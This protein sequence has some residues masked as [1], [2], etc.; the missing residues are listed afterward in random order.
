MQVARILPLLPPRLCPVNIRFQETSLLSCWPDSGMSLQFE[1]GLYKKEGEPAAKRH[2][3]ALSLNRKLGRALA[4]LYRVVA[5]LLPPAPTSHP[6]PTL[7]R[8]AGL[9]NRLWVLKLVL[10]I[11]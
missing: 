11:E 3:D 2:M 7:P 5:C 9:K 6:T 1:P 4:D 8:T 10:L